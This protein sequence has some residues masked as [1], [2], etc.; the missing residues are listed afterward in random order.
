MQ[1]V[2]SLLILLLLSHCSL[3]LPYIEFCKFLVVG[4]F[5]V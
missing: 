1:F 5:V 2:A 3:F 4:G